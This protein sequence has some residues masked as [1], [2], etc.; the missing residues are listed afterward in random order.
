MFLASEH[1]NCEL[2]I[3]YK[4]VAQFTPKD[5]KNWKDSVKQI[6]KFRSELLVFIYQPAKILP[7]SA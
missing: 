7:D 2:K 3:M 5:Y 6:S 4:M 1:D